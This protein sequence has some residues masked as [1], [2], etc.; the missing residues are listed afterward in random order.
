MKQLT[1]ILLSAFSAF[2]MLFVSAC[3]GPEGPAGPPGKD[4]TPGTAVCGVCHESSSLLLAKQ[5]QFHNSLHYKGTNFGTANRTQCAVCHTHEGFRESLTT[6]LDTTLAVIPNPTGPNCR[7][8]H[9]IHTKF[10]STDYQLTYTSPVK[11]RHGGQTVDFGAGNL[12]AKC[13]QAR[14]VNPMPVVGGDSINVA[15]FRWGPHY[16]MNA[17]ILAGMG[18]YEIPGPQEYPQKNPHKT[19]IKDG[20]ITCHMGPTFGAFAGGHSFKM[21]YLSGNQK[22]EHPASCATADCHPGAN[23]FDIDGKVTEIKNLIAQLRQKLID[24][25][26]LDVSRNPDGTNVLEEYIMLPG[27]RPKKFSSLEAGAVLNYLLV[28]KDRSNGIHNYKY[29]KALLVNTLNALQ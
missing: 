21:S 26:L 18:G 8:C 11:F 2:V 16:G 10:D 27:N 15:T 7:T 24:R 5:M 6:K 4:G 17:N 23:K 29:A 14:I 1:T 22:V 20:C 28:A 19:A 9:F 12:C 13:H 3:T 25:G